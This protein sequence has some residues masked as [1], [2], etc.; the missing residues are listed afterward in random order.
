MLDGDVALGQVYALEDHELE[1]G[2]S[3]P[4]KPTRALTSCASLSISRPAT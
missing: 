2:S 3:S 1:V 4:A